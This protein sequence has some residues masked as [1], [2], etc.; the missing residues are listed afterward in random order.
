[1]FRL[2][3][4]IAQ[5]LIKLYGRDADVATGQNRLAEAVRKLLGLPTGWNLIA[6]RVV[7]RMDPWL[8]A[9]FHDLAQH[10]LDA[11]V[12]AVDQVVRQFEPRRTGLDAVARPMDVYADLVAAGSEVRR[13]LYSAEAQAVFDRVLAAS[14]HEL[15]ALAPKSRNY[16][17][18]AAT[19]TVQTLSEL[20]QAVAGAPTNS[21][22]PPRVAGAD[23]E[24]AAEL[25]ASLA[26][27]EGEDH[28]PDEDRDTRIVTLLSTERMSSFARL[29][30]EL[31]ADQLKL[32]RWHL[33]MSSALYAGIHL[34][35]VVLRN[36][37]DA[38]IQPWN[39]A[40]P[41][42]Q[43][44]A[45][46]TSD[47]PDWILLPGKLVN[48]LTKQGQDLAKAKDLADRERRRRVTSGRADRDLTH[49]D[50]VAQLT[51]GTWRFLLPTKDDAGRWLLWREAVQ[52]AFP[53]LAPVTPLELTQHVA[54]LHELRN[55]IAHLEPTLGS[56]T[57]RGAYNSMRTIL[58]AVDPAA[59]EWFIS[60]QRITALLRIKPA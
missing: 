23:R 18:D 30:G 11:A 1:M 37:I 55:R 13:Q 5:V 31:E 43:Q 34:V 15:Q 36:A 20:R 54:Q 39:A 46:S 48:R 10:D 2:G 28:E 57:I 47:E 27:L 49:G 26:E 19:Y 42:V 32:Y 33:E 6:Y 41:E 21:A 4:S 8:N 56:S 51:F 53:S 9:E 58:G 17:I 44:L 35:E 52:H 38:R 50:L 16:L 7:Q 25:T 60:G 29:A 22:I 45:A 3:Q 40:Q 14:A 24:I 59:D 12:A